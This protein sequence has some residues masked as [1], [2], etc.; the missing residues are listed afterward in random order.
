MFG[1]SSQNSMACSTRMHCEA[2]MPPLRRPLAHT[3]A[4]AAVT[5]SPGH[6][7]G[8]EPGPGGG[9]G[10]RGQ[11]G[12]GN[13]VLAVST[14]GCDTKFLCTCGFRQPGPI[15]SM[16]PSILSLVPCPYRL[17]QALQPLNWSHFCCKAV[18]AYIAGGAKLSISRARLAGQIWSNPQGGSKTIS[19]QANSKAKWGRG[20]RGA[21]APSSSADSVS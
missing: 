3:P 17:E 2:A 4:S 20:G 18:L 9:Q 13:R 1:V 19:R 5:P 15:R 8:P 11:G 12:Q 7:Q 14:A 21:W 6:C 10:G 16:Q